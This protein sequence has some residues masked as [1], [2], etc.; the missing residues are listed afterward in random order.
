MPNT[1]PTL[2]SLD[3]DQIKA[4]LK[5]YLQTQAIFQDYNFDGSGLSILLDVLA[6]N[7]FWN[8]YLL[9]QTS[10]EF[11]IDSAQQRASLV[12]LAQQLGYVPRS[13]TCATANVNIV[14]SIEP[15]PSN[16]LTVSPVTIPKWTSLSS[17]IE[18]ETFKF[19][20]REAATASIQLTDTTYE[21]IAN[22]V[23]ITQGTHLTHQFTVSGNAA[24]T[25][26]LPNA[27]IDANTIEVVVQTSNS[28]LSTRVFTRATDLALI[29]ANA[30]VFWVRETFNGALELLFGNDIIGVALDAGN[31]IDVDYLISN[32]ADANEAH[33]FTLDDDIGGETLDRIDVNSDSAGGA[34]PESAESIRFLAPRAY[35]SQGRCVTA[36]DFK[37]TILQHVSGIS[38]VSVWGGENGDPTD[39][40]NRPAY[41]KVFIAIKPT[42]GSLL[43]TA[44]K[45]QILNTIIKP[46]SIITVTPEIIDPEYLYLKLFTVVKYDSTLTTL[47][48][49]EL[50]A[51]ILAALTTFSTQYLARFDSYFRFSKLVRAIDDADDGILN[52]L[53]TVTMKR[54]ITPTLNTRQSLTVKFR[55]PFYLSDANTPLMAC[56]SNRNTSFSHA[57]EAGIE[58]ANCFLESVRTSSG[59]DVL[60]MYRLDANSHKTVVQS[61]IGS[62]DYSTGT[63]Q[64]TSFAPTAIKDNVSTIALYAIPASS[65]IHPTQNQLLVLD[66]ADVTIVLH[67]DAVSSRTTAI[68][69]GTN[70]GGS[71]LTLPGA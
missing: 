64:L 43:S 26:V 1:I 49:A 38:S 11:F 22:D 21:L 65:D 25:F 53:T 10:S 35:A 28:V 14:F 36:D 57:D 8:A 15:Q 18:G 17:T 51:E 27:N 66:P 63:I 19:V 46:R 56:W 9:N 50:R 29:T 62:I 37:S 32:L 45:A 41:G 52:N 58:R 61:S 69:T 7:T 6:Y 59:Q 33:T 16:P 70:A 12:S 2:Q 23:T 48:E 30:Q 67:N 40:L 13:A 5:A 54:T 47:S 3:F 44:T 31:I 4:S 20:L 60:R 55:N 34:E 42:V 68:G 39:A 24:Q 71:S